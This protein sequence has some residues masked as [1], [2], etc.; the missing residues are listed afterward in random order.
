MKGQRKGVWSTRVK[1]ATTIKFKPGTEDSPQKHV[2][3]KRMN[4]IFVKI[5]KLAETIHIDQMGAFP[6]TSQQGYQYIMVSIHLDANYIFCELMKNRI[7]CKMIT[8]YQKMVDRMEIARL[9][10]KHHWLDNECSENFK[11]CF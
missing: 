7:E 4:D 11:K 10:L 2:A 8:A 3:I 5:Y 1:A 6:I 9:G